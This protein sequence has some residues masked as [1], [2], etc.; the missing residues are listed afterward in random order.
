VVLAKNS[1]KNADS[2]PVSPWSFDRAAE[3]S[4]ISRMAR[5]L[6]LTIPASQRAFQTIRNKMHRS[7]LRMTR[8]ASFQNP[9]ARAVRVTSAQPIL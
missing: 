2:G 1:S 4:G 7:R 9:I 3:W 5:K 6:K 8:A